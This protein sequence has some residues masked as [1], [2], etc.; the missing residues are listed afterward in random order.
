M[1]A[2]PRLQPHNLQWQGR[3]V[4]LGSDPTLHRMRAN[5]LVH[6]AAL[7]G[8]LP[9][10]TP[11]IYTLVGGRQVGKSTLLKQL[12]ARL[13]EEGIAP[14]RMAYV[15]CEPFVDAEELR[16]VLSDL[17]AVIAEG[18]RFCWLLLDEVTYVDGWDR[19]VKFLADAG[20]LDACFLIATG[21]DHLLIEDSLKR[22]PGRR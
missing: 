8:E 22:L 9:L 5:P 16:R 19:I 12:M 11:G 21:S 1:L 6:Q 2:D 4:F 17:L 15:T 7:V 3:E 20:T 13:L 10:H 14:E 18:G